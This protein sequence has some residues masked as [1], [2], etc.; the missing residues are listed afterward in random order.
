MFK[1]FA[2][3][4]H[5]KSRV[6]TKLQRTGDTTITIMRSK[7]ILDQKH[8]TWI[9]CSTDERKEQKEN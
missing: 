6:A 8:V 3:I 7:N 9:S 2:Y 5:M 1:D 4:M